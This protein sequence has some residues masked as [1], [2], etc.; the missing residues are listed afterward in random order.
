[1]LLTALTR[2]RA[3]LRQLA[4]KAS[5]THFDFTTNTMDIDAVDVDDPKFLFTPQKHQDAPERLD[6]PNVDDTDG[7]DELASNAFDA[8]PSRETRNVDV[9]S[10]ISP[11]PMSPGSKDKYERIYADAPSD[12]DDADILEI[13]GEYTED[14]TRY[15]YAR[16]DDG[17]VRRVRRMRVDWKC[18]LIVTLEGGLGVQ[19]KPHR[20][21]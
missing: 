14:D 7:E 4:S 15:L 3:C 19:A 20:S 12:A 2:R 17:I 5:S 18:M 21:L 9:F 6:S 1:M 16:Y 13:V 11:P 10:H 8:T